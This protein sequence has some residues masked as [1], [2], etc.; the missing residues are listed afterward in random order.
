[1]ATRGAI[2]AP[3]PGGLPRLLAGLGAAGATMTRADHLAVHGPLPDVA[4]EQLI[5]LVEGSGL[6]GRGGADFP[7]ATKLHAVAGRRG[8]KVV[9]VNGSETE[10]ASA[11]DRLLL[12]RLPHLV[13]D[14]AVLAARAIGAREAIV[15]IGDGVPSVSRSLEGGIAV[16]DDDIALQVVAGPEGYVTGEETAV[17]H[18]LER[19]VSKPKFVPPRP[20]E[21]G[22]RGRPT[23]IQNP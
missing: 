2:T 17:I 22:L 6:R 10:P 19:G 14:G 7:T 12:A 23:L 11:K 16:R 8:E 18:F 3:G 9:V 5:E 4:G 15:K 13:L 21:R 1:M 20:Y